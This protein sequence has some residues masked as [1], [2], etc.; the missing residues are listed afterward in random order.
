[1]YLS[2]HGVGETSA[3]RVRKTVD[4]VYLDVFCASL[5]FLLFFSFRGGN[6][7]RRVEARD[8]RTTAALV[9]VSDGPPHVVTQGFESGVLV[10]R[11]LVQDPH[12]VAHLDETRTQSGWRNVLVKAVRERLFKPRFHVRMKSH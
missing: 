10:S 11:K 12:G 1:V 2:K 7:S 3:P 8:E 9:K 5:A 4:D 6:V